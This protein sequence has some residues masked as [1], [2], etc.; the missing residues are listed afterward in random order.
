MGGRCVD[1][2]YLGLIYL[3]VGIAILL[4]NILVSFVCNIR[5]LHEKSLQLE[6]KDMPRQSNM[7]G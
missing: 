7:C 3:L 1:G 6:I 4:Q 5:T 2:E